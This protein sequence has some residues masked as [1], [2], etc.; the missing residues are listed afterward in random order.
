MLM[1]WR[2]GEWRPPGLSLVIGIVSV[3][4]GLTLEG[5][6]P[7]PNMPV[8]HAR[9]LEEG[10]IIQGTFPGAVTDID[11]NVHDIAALATENKLVVVTLKAA[12]CPVCQQQLVRLTHRLPEIRYCRVQF[13]VLAPGPRDEL[14]KIRERTGFSFPFVEDK[15]LRLARSLGIAMANDQIMPCMFQV[16]DD[17][18]I[19]WTQLGRNGAYFGD[20]A[21]ATYFSCGR[22]I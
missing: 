15:D 20:E 3:M 9:V 21:L 11:G 18:S 5:P 2:R 22:M 17:L 19:G 1:K 12:W 10:G 6:A 8:A 16:R 13:L 7:L 4:I 14:R